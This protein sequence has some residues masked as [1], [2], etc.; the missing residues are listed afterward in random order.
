MAGLNSFAVLVPFDG[1][2]LAVGYLV[3]NCDLMCIIA[4][5]GIAAYLAIY[6]VT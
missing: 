2:L 6:P 5:V 3:A 1:F 4:L